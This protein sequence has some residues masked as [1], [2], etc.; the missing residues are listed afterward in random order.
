M[1][2]YEIKKE[3]EGCIH[4]DDGTAV[5]T[6][7]G[8]V[9]TREALD[10]LN[11]ARDEKRENVALV[12][13]NRAAEAA[14][15]KEEIKNLQSRVKTLEKSVDWLKGYLSDDLAGQKFETRKVL[16]TFRTSTAVEVADEKQVPAAFKTVKESVAVNKAEIKKAIKAGQEVP[17]AALVERQNISIK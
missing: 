2:L 4:L 8:E 16:I 3:I 12:I 9:M 15:I 5:N 6:E 17:G 1:K 11:M 13:K 14:A 7:T 10:A